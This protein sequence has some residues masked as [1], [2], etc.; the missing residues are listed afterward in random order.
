[1][2]QLEF[3]NQLVCMLIED[4]QP[5]ATV[6]RLG[7]QKFCNACLPQY[8]LP[9]RRTVSRRLDDIYNVEKQKL[10]EALG[11]ARW[12]SATADA[13]SAH[14]R[15]F[16]GITVHFV[17]VDTLKMVS[18]ALACR[19]FKGAHTGDAIG[20]ILHQIFK[21]FG[22]VSKIQNVVT[23]NAANFAKAFTLFQSVQKP[24][25]E[26][27]DA[28]DVEDDGDNDAEEESLMST[29]NVGDLL[30]DITTRAPS[31]PMEADVQSD[32]DVADEPEEAVVLPPH[33]RCGNHSLNLVASV[34]ALKAR[35]DRAYQRSYDR[36]TGKVQALSNAVNR[37][38]KQNDAVQ[39][40]TG[41][42][43]LQPTCTRWCS[44]YYAVLRVVEIGIDKVNK[45]QT[46]LGQSLMTQ[47]DI[48]FLTGYVALMKPLVLAMKLLE[49]EN[50]CY[51]GQLIPTV[52]GLQNK[53]RKCSD[54]SMQPLAKALLNGI[55]A[56]FDSVLKNPD[57][58]V[59]TMLHPKFKLSF[60]PDEQKLQH[61]Q[62]LLSYIKEVQC[63]T[64]PATEI[65]TATTT[66]DADDDDLYSFL[67]EGE[68]SL[69]ASLSDQ[70]CFMRLIIIN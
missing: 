41:T 48:A 16:M 54:H 57:Y 20:R 63:E 61:R 42:T 46:E 70:V 28:Q 8:S 30:D 38:P 26:A 31:S 37:S 29:V 11:K 55:K 50:D 13:W 49:G 59:A 7:F 1:M 4:M 45:C 6:D 53:L 22:I 52:M 19:R 33:K 56:R 21:E 17:D 39:D 66:S 32:E 58:I 36:A 34:D 65:V 14:K 23:D 25:P 12:V 24:S 67:G 62:L 2:T 51:M 35:E 43:F 60:L 5:M 40:I 68:T 44:E 18:S 3:E 69:D 47:A 27:I 10:I 9:S 15:A 64:E